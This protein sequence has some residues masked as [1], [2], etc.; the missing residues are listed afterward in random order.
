MLGLV[1]RPPPH[2]TE[3]SHTALATLEQA[4]VRTLEAYCR[5]MQIED[6]TV[7]CACGGVCWISVSGNPLIG[8]S[9]G[10]GFV[11]AAHPFQ[12][13]PRISS[14]FAGRCVGRPAIA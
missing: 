12:G 3:P 8:I 4:E 11:G 13:F 10:F 9:G 14:N 5:H 1:S 2:P 7:K 6:P